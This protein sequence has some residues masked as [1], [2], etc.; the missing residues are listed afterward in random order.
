MLFRSSPIRTIDNITGINDA[1]VALSQW[2]DSGITPTYISANSFSLPGDQTSAFQVN[3]RVKLLVTAGTVH[4]YISSS[5][6]AAL[7]TVTV[8]LDSGALDIGLSSVQ[9]GL[10]TP[11]NTSMF[12]MQTSNIADNA[13]TSA[14]IADNAVTSAKIANANV[15][16]AKL[17]NAAKT[18]KIQHVD[19]SV[20]ANALAVVIHATVLDFRSTTLADGMPV[21]RSITSAAWLVVPNTATLGTINAIQARLAIIAI[22]NAGTIEAAIVNLAGGNNLDETTLISTTALSTAS[23]SANVIYS[24]VAR[25]SVAFR[26]VGL[27][28]ITQA[29]AGVWATAPTVVQGA[30][31][32][33]FAAMSSIGYGQNWQTVTRTSGITYYN[34]TGKPI[35]LTAQSVTGVATVVINGVTLT[36]TIPAGGAFTY[37]IPVKQSYSLSSSGGFVAN[38]L[39]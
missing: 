34:T 33:A 12:L 21:T 23:D 2:V 20:S 11:T 36:T 8:V 25:T 16:L 37:V 32:Q 29:S 24:A 39:R 9:L 13:V 18:S 17:E 15:T 30:G 5:A 1:S 19:S 26:V 35:T 28:D 6:F 10:I 38:E 7:T 31:G 3:R 22:D 27:I 4:G 14:K